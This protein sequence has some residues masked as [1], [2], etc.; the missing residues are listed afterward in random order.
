MSHAEFF[1]KTS[2][3]AGDSASLQPG[4]GTLRL[5]AFLK[6]KI[7]FEREE[8]QAIDEIQE[9]MTGRLMVIGRTV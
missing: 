9:N 5:L 1:G 7:T 6:I 4:F 2:S 3:H 8:F